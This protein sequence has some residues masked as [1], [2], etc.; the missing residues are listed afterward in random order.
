MSKVSVDAIRILMVED[1]EDDV[2][3][4]QRALK[5]AN[6]WNQV[7]VVRDGEEALD[8]LYN[9]GAFADK[10]AYPRPGLI[11]LDLSLPGVDGREVLER[12]AD[13]PDLKDIPIVIVST[14]DYEK[15]IEFGRA[16]GVE[17][18]IIKP[19]GPDNI[20]EAIGRMTS[21]RVILGSVA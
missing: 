7:D 3:L 11:L 20:I 6:I 8:Y 4:T 18:Y 15:D 1:D 12:V 5:K 10:E 16:Q 17:N 19:I 13:E 21:F 14:S 2:L 9:E